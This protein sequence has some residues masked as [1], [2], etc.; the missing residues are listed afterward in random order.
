MSE[1]GEILKSLDLCLG[2]INTPSS[3]RII[4]DSLVYAVLLLKTSIQSIGA[5]A[6]QEVV[7]VC[8]KLDILPVTNP[9][10]GEIPVEA[11]IDPASENP[12]LLGVTVIV[13]EQMADCPVYVNLYPT[14]TNL[15]DAE[16]MGHSH[17]SR[18]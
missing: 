2:K 8:A 3:G 6:G 1:V 13:P 16:S 18:D 10:V 9:G 12:T 14:L 7:G 5:P 4:T 11:V 15:A 17:Y